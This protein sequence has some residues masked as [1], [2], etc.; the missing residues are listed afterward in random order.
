[1]LGERLSLI[2]GE[3]EG[4]K[5]GDKDFEILGLK[6]GLKLSE[7]LGLKLGESD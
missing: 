7:M 4:L 1:M 2:L 3:V 6:L 5:L